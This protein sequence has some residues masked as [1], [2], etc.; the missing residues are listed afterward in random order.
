MVGLKSSISKVEMD[1]LEDGVQPCNKSLCL[2]VASGFCYILYISVSK[3][4]SI[5]RLRCN[6]FDTREEG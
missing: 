6:S 2:R 3:E 1:L 5:Y 4:K